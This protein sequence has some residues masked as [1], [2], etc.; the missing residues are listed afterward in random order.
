MLCAIVSQYDVLSKNV[1]LILAALFIIFAVIP[2]VWYLSHKKKKTARMR[3]I[4]K[5][6]NPDDHHKIVFNECRQISC[7]L[8]TPRTVHTA[9]TC[10]DCRKS[11]YEKSPY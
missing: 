7:F 6:A 4:L 5:E 8:I 1:W 11:L 2:I 3:R 10:C 9:D